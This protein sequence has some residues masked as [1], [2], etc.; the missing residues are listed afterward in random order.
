[1]DNATSGL[2]GC[3]ELATVLF[4]CSWSWWGGIYVAQALCPCMYPL[5]ANASYGTITLL[6]DEQSVKM[7]QHL[8]HAVKTGNGCSCAIPVIDP[9][10]LVYFAER[11]EYLP[12]GR[13][14]RN[15]GKLLVAIDVALERYGVYAAVLAG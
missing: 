9:E 15:L 14:R 12:E 7:V 2:A 5:W 1:M 13:E 8:R 6:S 11:I 10:R 3:N 4:E